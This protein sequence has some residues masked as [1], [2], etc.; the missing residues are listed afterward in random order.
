MCSFYYSYGEKTQ[1]AING[2]KAS[3]RAEKQNDNRKDNKALM[4]VIFITKFTKIWAKMS[5]DVFPN[6]YKPIC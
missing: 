2:L 5:I 3:D 4:S 6:T 1:K